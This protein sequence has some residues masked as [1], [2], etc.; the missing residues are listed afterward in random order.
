M[1]CK[2]CNLHNKTIFMTTRFY[3]P[4]TAPD[5]KMTRIWIRLVDG[6]DLIMY[7]KTEEH[8][9]GKYWD[10]KTHWIASRAKFDRE[11]ELTSALNDLKTN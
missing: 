5:D 2:N 6:R 8:I 1:L 4:K 11:R 7:A 3:I 9:L 10:N